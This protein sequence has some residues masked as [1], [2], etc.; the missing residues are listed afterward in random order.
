MIVEA[1]EKITLLKLEQVRVRSINDALENLIDVSSAWRF[2]YNNPDIS[3]TLSS[4]LSDVDILEDPENKRF[5]PETVHRSG[6]GV[7]PGIVEEI[8]IPTFLK[9]FK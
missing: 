7:P 5:L 2:I 8:H 3:L 9:R 1:R 4:I 6:E